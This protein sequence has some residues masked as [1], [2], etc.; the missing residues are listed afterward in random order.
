MSK[1]NIVF[2]LTIVLVLLS[3]CSSQGANQ[4]QETSTG[5]LQIDP[6]VSGF[7]GPYKGQFQ[8]IADKYKSNTLVKG[9]IQDEKIGEEELDEVAEV[10]EKCL[11]EF[12]AT[13]SYRVQGDYTTPLISFGSEKNR[14]KTDELENECQVKSAFNDLV[15]LSYDISQGF[16]DG[17]IMKIEAFK[18]LAE[19][20]V[21]HNLAP[22]GYSTYEL[23]NDIDM[24]AGIYKKYMIEG[25]T[26]DKDKYLSCQN[27]PLE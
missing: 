25:T 27:S 12:G 16:S 14:L 23:L 10:F 8:E 11:A 3:G 1:R 7:I 4:P 2:T 21:R 6:T 24:E 9:I 17:E 13:I 5:A 20:L 18:I 26:S 19:C 15:F 22:K